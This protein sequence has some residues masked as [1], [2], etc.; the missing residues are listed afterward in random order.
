MFYTIAKGRKQ[1][2]CPLTDEWINK[3][4]HVPTM[5]YQP[6]FKRRGILIS[7]YMDEPLRH[8]AKW[9]KPKTKENIAWFPLCENTAQSLT[10]TERRMGT[11]GTRGTGTGSY[12]LRGTGLQ[13]GK[14]TRLLWR[15][16]V[17]MVVKQVN[18]LNASELYT[19]V[20]KMV[21]LCYVFFT[22][23]KRALMEFPSWLSG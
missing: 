15:R 8:F 19:K 20:V 1:H 23:T 4:W 5:K 7:Y 18:V 16:M 12:C 3:M 17:V 14:I 10:E 9:N 21:N 13:F 22:T 6:A 11:L 2:L